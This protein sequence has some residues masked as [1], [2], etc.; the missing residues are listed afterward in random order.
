MSAREGD[1]NAF[2]LTLDRDANFDGVWTAGGIGVEMGFA[3]AP[4]HNMAGLVTAGLFNKGF[5]AQISGL[6]PLQNN[7]KSDVFLLYTAPR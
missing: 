5:D 4:L 2:M 7:G 3:V 1:A 6:E